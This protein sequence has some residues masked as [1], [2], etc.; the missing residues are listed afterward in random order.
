MVKL[1]ITWFPLVKPIG[2]IAYIMLNL[3]CIVLS[4]NHQ[5]NLQ[6][7]RNIHHYICYHI[8]VDLQLL[9]WLLS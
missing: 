9:L 1:R 3:C 8:I 5:H 6:G 2:K 4:M 7:M